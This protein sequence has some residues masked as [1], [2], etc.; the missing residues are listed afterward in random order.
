M[1]AARQA[2]EF[3]LAVN[4]SGGY[5]H[6]SPGEGHGFCAYADVALAVN[7]LR[8]TGALKETDRIVY[9]DLDAHQGNGVCRS[10][11][12]DRR[13]F[14]YDQYNRNI[15]PMDARAQRRVDC[16]VSLP[17]RC[18]ESNYL[19]ALK[20]NLPRFLDSLLGGD[21]LRLG[22]YNAGTDVYAGDSLGGLNVSASGVLARDQFVLQELISRHIPTVVLLSGGYSRESYRL[23]AEMVGYILQ[24]WG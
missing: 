17:S 11:V 19:E 5:H 23:V 4:L 7:A 15:F 22:I 21:G 2:V 18:P 10:F 6:A 14:I 16:D 9:V 3:G 24:A 20:S 1:L 8:E 13:M 12:D